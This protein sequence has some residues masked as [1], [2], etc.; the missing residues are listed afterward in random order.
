MKLKLF[1]ILNLSLVIF[2]ACEKDKNLT[3][4]TVDES[5][6]RTTLVYI[7]ADNS[8]YSYAKLDLTEME[9][10][11]AK[12]DDTDNNNL[13]VYIDDYSTPRLLRIK[14]EDDEVVVD[15][16]YSYAEQNSLD[17]DIMS[18]VINQALTAY[19]ADSY[20]LVLWSH[21]NGWLPGTDQDEE[22]TKAFGEDLDNNPSSDGTQMDILDLKTAL[23]A[24]PKFNF[25]L[26]DACDMQGIE[27]AYELR[28]CA[29]YFIASPGEIPAYGAPYDDVVPAFY[30]GA[31]A[32]AEADSV[33]HAYF[34]DYKENYSYSA[35]DDGNFTNRAG[36]GGYTGGTSSSSSYP[37]GVSISVI[38]SENLEALA[39]ATKNIL[40]AYIAN[41]DSVETSDIMNYDDNYYN[42]YYDLDGFIKSLTGEDNNY[43]TWKAA[44]DAAVPLFL[45]T[46]YTYSSYANDGLGGMSSMADATGVSTYIPNNENFFDAYYW[47]FYLKYYP[48]YS[49]VIYAYQPYYNEYYQKY[50]WDTDAGWNAIGW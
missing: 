40:T 45:T 5:T 1:I 28:N 24:C 6:T 37:Y 21:G 15:T 36:T 26:F 27:V 13:L 42:F 4:T 46:D 39:S 2:S 9:E 10:G 43:T 49:S 48:Q 44:Y 17:V 33:A 19:E 22:T 12:L 41:S 35:G 3:S 8:L 31:D 16:L 25:I 7:V 50:S 20:G 34:N 18:G 30:A 11:Y 47:S 29:S 14:K 23:E 38:A 32:S